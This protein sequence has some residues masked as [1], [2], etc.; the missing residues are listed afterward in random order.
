MGKP[1]RSKP[2]TRSRGR[3]EDNIKKETQEIECGV[4][5]IDLDQ[6]GNKWPTL[7]KTVM[8]FRVQ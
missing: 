2:L 7:E 3:W 8:N 5:W 1:E 6:D 4:G